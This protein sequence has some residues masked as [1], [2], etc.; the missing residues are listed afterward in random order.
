M[1]TSGLDST[2]GTALIGGMV[3]QQAMPTFGGGT[4]TSGKLKLMSAT[5]SETGDGTEIATSASYPAGGIAFT[6]SG[7]WGTPAYS[8]GTASVTSAAAVTQTGMP[9]AT[10]ISVSIW[11]TAGTP[12]RWW[13]EGSAA[14]TSVTTNLGDTLTFAS[15]SISASLTI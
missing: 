2:T 7:F 15:G 6:L 12:K 13:W 9:A 4:G 3:G 8:S 1:A 11:D 10:I 5:A 14:F